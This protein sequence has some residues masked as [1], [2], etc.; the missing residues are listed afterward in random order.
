MPDQATGLHDTADGVLK[1]RSDP[2]AEAGEHKGGQ[3]RRDQQQNGQIPDRTLTAVGAGPPL[4]RLTDSA[5]HSE[6]SASEIH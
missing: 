4:H 2:P 1:A 5:Q 3:D 6:N